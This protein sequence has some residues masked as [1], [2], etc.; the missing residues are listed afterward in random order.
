MHLFVVGYSTPAPE[1]ANRKCGQKKISHVFEK[2]VE[3]IKVFTL[4]YECNSNHP[5]PFEILFRQITTFIIVLVA[6][7]FGLQTLWLIDFTKIFQLKGLK[8]TLWG[9]AKLN[10]QI[11]PRRVQDILYPIF[12]FQLAFWL[13]IRHSMSPLNNIYDFWWIF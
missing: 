1:M 12:C 8:P 7:V 10:P 11:L 9:T 13:N 3:L 4:Q 5:F 2:K 6:F